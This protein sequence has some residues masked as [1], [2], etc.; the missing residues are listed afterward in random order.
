MLANSSLATLFSPQES[1]YSAASE[2]WCVARKTDPHC[3]AL[4]RRHYSWEKNK[5]STDS[6]LKNGI[7][8]PGETLVLVSPNADAVFVWQKQKF[9]N[10]NQDGVNCCIFRNE[11]DVRSSDLIRDA[12]RLAWEIWPE[13]R[14]FTFVNPA[15]VRPIKRRGEPVY[16]FC[17]RKAGWAQCGQ[18]AKGLLIL[19]VFP[20]AH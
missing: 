17:Y 8:G 18:T 9:R 19:E 2:F 16:G 6:L 13:E 5:A 4:Y 12:C 10:D 11:S 1:G 3:C 14:L 15:K 7:A 20:N